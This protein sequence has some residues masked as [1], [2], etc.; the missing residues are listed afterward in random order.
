MGKR[1][2]F[3]LMNAYRE[4][5]L[6]FAVAWAEGYASLVNGCTCGRASCSR[7]GSKRQRAREEKQGHRDGGDFLADLVHIHVD[8]LGN[9]ARLNSAYT[10]LATRFLNR[11]YQNAVSDDSYADCS[12][13][14]RLVVRNRVSAPAVLM[15]CNPTGDAA[16]VEIS[17]ASKDGHLSAKLTKLDDNEPLEEKAEFRLSRPQGRSLDDW[18]LAAGDEEK[19][20]L[21]VQRC[22]APVGEYYARIKVKLDGSVQHFRVLVDVIE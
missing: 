3:D 4:A 22:Q 2:W 11:A 18:E 7:C 6:D 17:R 1:S 19:L 21:E 13:D 5:T 9:L 8:Y 16:D 20:Y 14:V 12:A 10:S 15:I